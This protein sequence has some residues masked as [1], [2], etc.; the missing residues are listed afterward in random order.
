MI[1]TISGLHGTGKSTIGKLIAKALGLTF[2]STGEAFRE[3]AHEKK[4][5]LK[6]FT[7]YAENNPDIDLELD[8]KVIEIAKKGNIIVDSQLSGFLLEN[9]ADFRIHLVCPID[10]RVNRMGFRD[11]TPYKEKLKETTL[12]ERSEA[13]RFKKLYN[14]DITDLNKIDENFDLIINTENLTIEQVVDIILKKLDEV[15]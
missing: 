4:M 3:L 13:I 15:A 2:Y 12:R 5:T 6:E 7:E 14:I 9:I 10:V 1:I 11:Q 8:N